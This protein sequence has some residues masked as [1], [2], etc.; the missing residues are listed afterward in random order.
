M[1]G[2]GRIAGADPGDLNRNLM[3][4]LA[5][6]RTDPGRSHVDRRLQRLRDGRRAP[7]IAA[8]VSGSVPTAGLS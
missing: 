5:L 7:S 6:H 2:T 8:R 4:R 3:D 1:L